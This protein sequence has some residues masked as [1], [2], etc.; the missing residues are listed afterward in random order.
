[1]QPQMSGACG[2]A[3]TYL[4]RRHEEDTASRPHNLHFPTPGTIEICMQVPD[5]AASTT[6]YS[7]RIHLPR[8]GG[9]E[10]AYL[11]SLYAYQTGKWGCTPKASICKQGPHCTGERY[12]TD[13]F[14]LRE[15]SQN[16]P[17]RQP[18][19][20]EQADLMLAFSRPPPPFVVHDVRRLLA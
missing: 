11:R 16:G 15:H 1:M 17:A 14:S 13:G 8:N 18:R 9:R 4:P 5:R 19:S 10:G 2:D 20:P 3:M 7:K 6:E 12:Q